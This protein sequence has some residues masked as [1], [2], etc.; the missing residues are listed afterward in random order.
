MI[1]KEFKNRRASKMREQTVQLQHS[2]V[3]NESYVLTGNDKLALTVIHQRKLIIAPTLD[4]DLGYRYPEAEKI[5]RVSTGEIV[6]KLNSLWK[7]EYLQRDLCATIVKCPKCGAYKLILRIQCPYCGSFKLIK[8]N[9]IKHYPCGHI[10]FEN[11]FI[12]TNELFCPN[13]NKKLEKLGLDYMR[14]GVWYGCLECEKR[15]GE[16]KELLHCSDCD[17]NYERDDLV[18]EPIFSFK[19]DEIKVGD[20]LLDIDIKRLDEALSEKWIVEIPGKIVG[21]S[22]IEHN[23]SVALTSRGLLGKKAFIDIEYATNLVDEYVIMQF[24]AKLVDVKSD[25]GL[26]VGIPQF[27]K[28]AKRLA[29]TYKIKVLEENRLTD[30]IDKII[31]YLDSVEVKVP[32]A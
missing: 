23:F 17:K 11:E 6:D 30:L 29:E 27:S 13:C 9:S 10:D 12:K 8:G 24:F 15:F 28:E 7:M 22:G 1:Q 19:I 16:P 18:L 20:L 21:E 5:F 26:L 25:I 32:N 3:D 4:V 14:I 31:G 2:H